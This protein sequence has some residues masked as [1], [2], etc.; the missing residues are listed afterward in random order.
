[1]GAGSRVIFITGDFTPRD[2]A[3]VSPS[4][5]PRI[6]DPLHPHDKPRVSVGEEKA[7]GLT[8]RTTF[9]DP[10]ITPLAG[11]F[12]KV[13]ATAPEAPG[14]SAEESEITVSS[15]ACRWNLGEAKVEISVATPPAPIG[16]CVKN[17]HWCPKP[18]TSHFSRLK[19]QNL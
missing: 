18:V 9:R 5:L 2:F 15:I 13:G 4:T 6:T 3:A 19:I 11:G 7:I 17:P 10:G 1:M 8:L 14:D 16:T 12:P